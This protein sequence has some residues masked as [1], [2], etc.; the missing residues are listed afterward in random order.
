MQRF[1]RNIARRY[2]QGRIAEHGVWE[3]KLCAVCKKWI[4]NTPILPATDDHISLIGKVCKK[5]QRQSIQVWQ[6]GSL[7][8][9][10]KDYYNRKQDNTVLQVLDLYI[11]KSIRSKKVNAADYGLLAFAVL[12]DEPCEAL[13]SD[14]LK[15]IENSM[16]KNQTILY[17]PQA[18]NCAFVDTI[19]FVCPFLVKY[20]LQT[21]QQTYIELAKKQIE[22]YIE[23]GTEKNSGLPFHAYLIEEKI[24]LGI[25]DWARGLAWLLIGMMDSYIC[26]L[27]AGQDDIFLKQTI[28]KY[29]DILVELQREV[30]SFSWQ[31]LTQSRESDSSATA[32]F[33]WYL[34]NCADIFGEQ[35]YLVRAK[36]CREFLMMVTYS[37]GVIDFCQGDTLGVGMYSRQFDIM[38]FAQG[39]AL[40]LEE[41]LNVKQ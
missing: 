19:G 7:C 32:V 18:K 22:N 2:L 25:C 5:E 12:G 11:Q 35:E 17:K 4:L 36:K 30:G 27:E 8:L 41:K 39:F 37:N 16:G 31:L 14:F 23:N 21:K 34:A 40:R 15:Y 9:G 10:L 1:I 29:A 20:G 26:I 38:P 28:K 3:R 6:E 13:V 33:G 24:P